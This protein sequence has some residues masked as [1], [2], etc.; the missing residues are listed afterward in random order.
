MAC[1]I[2]VYAFQS[3]LPRRERRNKSF[4]K[5]R[6]NTNFNPRSRVGSDRSFHGAVDQHGGFQSTLPRR[7]RRRR[8][9]LYTATLGFQSTLP[10]RER[11]HRSRSS[12]C[13]GYFNP[14]SRVGS[15]LRRYMAGEPEEKFQSTL[16][17]RERPA[18]GKKP[19]AGWGFQSTLPRRERLILVVNPVDYFQHFNP[20]SRVGSDSARLQAVY[21]LPISIHAPA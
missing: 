12:G 16:P 2:G 21:L 18:V 15:D 8:R 4:S 9:K 20:R 3:T 5:K 14:R 7:E 13:G 17:R 11:R 19:A 1:C 10:R 6:L